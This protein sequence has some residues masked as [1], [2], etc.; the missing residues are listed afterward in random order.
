MEWMD[1]KC[2]CLWARPGNPRYIQYHD[3]EWGIPVY[4]DHKLFE[5]L[6]LESFQAGLSWE[7]VLDKRDAFRAA[8]D[9]FELNKV[10]EYDD[11]KTAQLLSNPAIIRNRLKVRAAVGN[12]KVFRKI[13]EE[14]GTFSR[15]L[16]G[17]TGGKV[18]YE[19]GMTRSDLSDR[20]SQD[21]KKRGM[22]FVG[23]TTIYAYLQAVG[24][25]YSHDKGCFL[26][27]KD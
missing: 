6:V 26:E 13:Q 18:V 3:S 19:K 20:I 4:E 10:C 21:L 8:F 16:W 12:A 23:S 15:Y 27:H 14:F 24:V 2:R 7:C 11:E 1:H 22:T 25:V 5:M 17:W 9:N